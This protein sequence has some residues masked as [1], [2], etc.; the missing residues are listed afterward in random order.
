[1]VK[2][3][4]AWRRG[5]R[6]VREVVGEWGRAGPAGGAGGDC[7]VAAWRAAA[8]RRLADRPTADRAIAVDVRAAGEVLKPLAR[9]C[10]ADLERFLT[11]IALGAEADVLDPRAGAITLLTLHAAKGLEFGAG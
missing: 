9:R 11:E 7:G 5:G 1:S 6:G 2:R 8:V 10:G 4:T 3:A